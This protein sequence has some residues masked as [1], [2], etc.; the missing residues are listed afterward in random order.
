[1]PNTSVPIDTI[2]RVAIYDIPMD[3]VDYL[4]HDA[5]T[6]VVTNIMYEDG[7]CV[8][9]CSC[10]ETANYLREFM[11]DDTDYYADWYVDA[12]QTIEYSEEEEQEQEHEEESEGDYD[13]CVC[14]D[15]LDVH[16]RCRECDLGLHGI[17][18]YRY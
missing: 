8:V 14:G 13:R 4:F 12:D 1:M 11:I 6:Y 15:L 17:N 3:M 9:T 5:D 10:H 2:C 18:Q 7:L 16:G